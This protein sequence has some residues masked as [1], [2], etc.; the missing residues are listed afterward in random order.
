MYLCSH[1]IL[2]RRRHIHNIV[3]PTRAGFHLN[4]FN[5]HI[6]IYLY[7]HKYID[8][9]I[10]IMIIY[11]LVGLPDE[12]LQST[13]ERSKETIGS[14]IVVHPHLIITLR[15]LYTHTTIFLRCIWCLDGFLGFTSW[16]ILSAVVVLAY[17]L[18]KFFLIQFLS[19]ENKFF[20]YKAIFQYCFWHSCDC[21]HKMTQLWVYCLNN[22]DNILIYKNIWNKCAGA[23]WLRTAIL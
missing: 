17:L 2:F 19:A 22:Y 4:G 6:H 20:F 1:V 13:G 16:I 21:E 3:V 5:A 10:C 15:S 9:Y 7:I 12:R 18:Y 8:L 23:Y 11:D 14:C